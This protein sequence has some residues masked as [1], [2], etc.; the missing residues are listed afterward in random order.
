MMLC[1]SLYA[2]P[3]LRLRLSVTQPDGT[4]LNMVKGGDEWLS[5]YLTDDG[6]VV[7]GNGALGFCY[8]TAWSESGWTVSDVA[9]HDSDNR[10]IA[11]Q[12]WLAANGMTELEAQTAGAK[13]RKS[14]ATRKIGVSDNPK[15]DLVYPIVLVEF[16]DL[17]FSVTNAVDTFN[18]QFN[19]E[20][21]AGGSARG[22]VRDYFMAQSKNIYRPTFNIV[23]KIKLPK[24]KAYYGAHSGSSNDSHTFE[25]AREV[26]SRLQN[27]G[28][29]LSQYVDK[30]G[31][32]PIV[33]IVFAGMGENSSWD[34][35]ALWS[36]F[37]PTK[38]TSNGV[39]VNSYLVVNEIMPSLSR[40]AETSKVDTLYN[41][42]GI[43]TFCHEF[44]HFLGL[45]DFYNTYN[46]S[47]MVAMSLWSIM[48]YGQYYRNGATPVGYTAYEKNFMGWM[49]IDTLQT[50]KQVVNINALG[51]ENENAY[52]IFNDNDRSKCEYWILENRQPSTWYPAALG[53]GMLVVHVD[54]LSSSWSNNTVNT[55]SSHKRM[56]F[57]AA[58]NDIK[59]E[60]AS[61]PADYKGDLFPGTTGNT[62]LSDETT[63]NFQQFNGTS[64]GKYLTN[65][66]DT[67]GIVSFVYMAEGIL[68]APQNIEVAANE[69]VTSLSA[70]W[71]AV[72]NATSY[73]LELADGTGTVYTAV[74]DTNAVDLGAFESYKNLTLKVTALADNY[75]QSAASALDFSN[76]VGIKTIARPDTHILYNV[77][78]PSGVLVL[79]NATEEQASLTLQRGIYILRG[80]SSARK[81]LVR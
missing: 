34:E 70:K 2:S 48:D 5:Y 24:T 29:D 18:A 14:L 47:S 20:G 22:S 71:T 64:V 44:S 59:F 74:T 12:Q 49:K 81:I 9:A 8:A 67:N 61:K 53:S 6:H 4:C 10:D 33:G 17:E 63:P 50:E 32:V 35:D 80:H 66:T 72:D 30:T 42:E 43:G 21:F 52:Y 28:T 36:S 79:S 1:V 77:Y 7:A 38:F 51:A 15:G 65:I 13:S 27:S 11:E 62:R 3:A 55:S 76:P 40:N 19:K 41:I 57:I 56:S 39:Q 16:S 25:L 45:P 54:Y 69:N 26:V 46:S 73:T 78:T 68:S 31:G 60:T 58:D 75:I 37:Y 23:G